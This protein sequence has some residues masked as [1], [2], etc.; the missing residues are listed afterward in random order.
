MEY[1]IG[2]GLHLVYEVLRDIG[3]VIAGVLALLAGLL[4]YRAGV[5]Q[6]NATRKAAA[7]QIAAIRKQMMQASAATAESDFRLRKSIM[8]ALSVETSRIKDLANILSEVVIAESGADKSAL[9]TVETYKTYMIFTYGEL[10]DGGGAFALLTGDVLD[11]IARLV[12]S[13]DQLNSELDAKVPFGLL[14][15][16]EIRAALERIIRRAD[17]LEHALAEFAHQYSL[18]EPARLDVRTE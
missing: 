9:P 5:R 6:A 3:T 10:R 18:A 14:E 8:L 2:R 17:E 15:K 11:A 4:A 13:V 1:D 12:S 16:T 7:D